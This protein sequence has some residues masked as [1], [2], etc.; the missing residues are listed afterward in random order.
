MRDFVN[1]IEKQLIYNGDVFIKLEDVEGVENIE[2][3]KLNKE[4]VIKTHNYFF[5]NFEEKKITVKYFADVLYQAIK[6]IIKET[7]TLEYKLSPEYIKRM[8][9]VLEAFGDADFNG[10][11]MD[12]N[13][14]FRLFRYYI[15]NESVP[16]NG[17]PLKGM[18]ILGMLETRVLKFDKVIVFDCN[19]G[20]IPSA[21]KYDPLLSFNIRAIL[22][23]PSYKEHEALY[24]YHFRRL[25][26]GAKESHLIYIKTDK[27]IRSRF[28]EEIVWEE[29]KKAKKIDIEELRPYSLKFKTEITAKDYAI[30]KNEKIINDIMSKKLSPTAVDTY[31]N[32]PAKFYY[33]YV[34]GLKEPEE[35][36]EEI[37]ANKIGTFIHKALKK[38][39]E[40]FIN[41]EYSYNN[42]CK[43]EIEGLIED[44]FLKEFKYK[45]D[46]GEHFLVKE[47]TKRLLLDFI[48]EDAK[49]KPIILEVETEKCAY[50]PLDNNKNIM[51]RGF[52]DRI[53]QRSGGIFI[54]DYKT[55]RAIKPKVNKLLECNSGLKDRKKMK[56]LIGSFQLPIYL[57]LC[58]NENDALNCETGIPAQRADQWAGGSRRS[59]TINAGIDFDYSDYNKLNASIYII[60]KKEKS[61]LFDKSKNKNININISGVMENIIIPSLKRL[62]QE[63]LD[64]S[65]PFTADNSNEE[66]CDK[67]CHFSIM[68][69]ANY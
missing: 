39:Y 31:L 59:E 43:K 18:Q 3:E 5:R 36:E 54:I 52:I 11:L 67:Y 35:I 6:L 62:V 44:F 22:G 45:E 55:G 30:K 27:N 63:I 1:K 17:I 56:E 47:I 34:I 9:A 23:M 33:S 29:E 51:L 46:N 13:C 69:K 66:Y 50:L 7:N 58:K 24:R 10:E 42:D 4:N 32:C 14:V 64:E 48:K 21:K 41:K 2:K 37:Q 38:F 53:D 20:I 15:N 19:E 57:Y 12:K 26:S 16:F 25:I 8:I 60:S 28:I 40:K 49:E 65:T 68:C 61:D